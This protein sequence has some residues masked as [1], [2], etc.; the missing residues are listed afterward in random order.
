MNG[1]KLWIPLLLGIGWLGVSA[2]LL[3]VLSFFA[4]TEW[5]RA[6]GFFLAGV[7]AAPLGLL[8]AH[9]RTASLSA[10]TE[11]EIARRVTDSL[12]KAVELLGH[13]EIAVRQGGI[14]ALGRIAA[15]NPKE[16]PKIMSII[17][18]Y[19]RHRSRAYVD[20]EYNKWM[21]KNKSMSLDKF[22]ENTLSKRPS[23]ID[24]EAAVAVIR[25][26]NAEFDAG[27]ILDLSEAFLCRVNFSGTL[28]NRVNFKRSVLRDCNFA[29]A[30]LMGAEMEKANFAN[31][32]FDGANMSHVVAED[33]IFEHADMAGV[34][35]QEAELL[36]AFFQ[37]AML[38]EVNFDGT[39]MFNAIFNEA[40]LR[41]AKF[42]RVGLWDAEFHKAFLV[43]AKFHNVDLTTADFSGANFSAAN[44]DNVIAGCAI[45]KEA[46]LFDAN[47]TGI[48]GITAEQI[49]TTQGNSSTKLPKG[50][51]HPADWLEPIPRKA[52]TPE[53]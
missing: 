6:A 9:R 45:F 27:L 1:K 20:E 53:K 2:I 37:N 17:A 32:K 5:I 3:G 19:I 40:N 11:N 28:L 21:K 31:S 33:A 47:L 26:R 24:L 23:P 25:E 14:Y 7:G 22:I 39:Y 50:M 52:D 16:H 51:E 12:T 44:F 36:S 43:D 38:H 10:Q 4:D 41:G 30:K 49:K 35:F 29:E 34:N 46:T 18:A 15:E 13:A 48:K 42:H 8:L